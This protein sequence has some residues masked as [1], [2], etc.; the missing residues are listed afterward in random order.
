MP[1]SLTKQ[2]KKTISLENINEKFIKYFF[3]L[4]S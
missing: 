3:K 1:N 4:N 2:Q